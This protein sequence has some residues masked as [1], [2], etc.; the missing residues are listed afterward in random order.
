MKALEVAGIT[1]KNVC[2]MKGGDRNGPKTESMG[3][4]DYD[5]A[6][7]RISSFKVLSLKKIKN[8]K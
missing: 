3:S 1:P 4:V 5:T 7:L 8:K 6:I 2:T